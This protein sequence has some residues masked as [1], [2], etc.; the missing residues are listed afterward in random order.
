MVFQEVA[1]PQSQKPKNRRDLENELFGGSDLSSQSGLSVRDNEGEAAEHGIYYDDTDYDYM[2]HMRDLGGNTGGE[3]V[4]VD[5]PGADKGKGKQKQS[6]EDA[7]KE[8]DLEHEKNAQAAQGKI[9][10]ESIL[11]SQELRQQTYQNQQDVPDELAGFQPDMDP[12]LREVLEALEDEA[13]VDT[14]ETDD[15]FSSIA[16]DKREL[17]LDEFEDQLYYDHADQ[18]QNEDDDGWESDRTARPSDHEDLVLPPSQPPPSSSL[19][20]STTTDAST[21]P[22]NQAQ[23]SAQVS[24]DGAFMST[25]R[26]LPPSLKAPTQPAKSKNPGAPPSLLASTSSS[27]FP[28]GTKRKKRK[29]ALTATSGYSMTSSSLARTEGLT[30]LDAR[31]DKI[32]ADYENDDDDDDGV[33][34]TSSMASGMSQASGLSKVSGVSG[35]SGRSWRTATSTKSLSESLAERKDLDGMMDEFLGGFKV[36]GK[37][38]VKKEGKMGGIREL[39]EIRRELGPA[40]IRA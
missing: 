37:R 29:G 30:T 11:P 34:D 23:V 33:D 40:R 35:M 10:D 5:A 39:D 2:Q 31:F 12:R 25:F 21:S 6:L 36:T 24:D 1:P 19:F 17:S 7:L 13:Y 3:T 8:L 4:W 32:L 15:F 27:L 26:S 28:P 9:V 16:T 38:R 18:N 20:P 22:S 14:D